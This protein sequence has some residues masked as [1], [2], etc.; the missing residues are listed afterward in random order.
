MNKG[1]IV[2]HSTRRPLAE[3][4]VAELRTRAGDY[5]QMAVTATTEPVKA[6]LLRLA[7]RFD[8]LADQKE[9]T[10]GH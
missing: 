4:C 5:R 1:M 3:Q 8:A 2:P 6:S 7:A 9:R 10:A